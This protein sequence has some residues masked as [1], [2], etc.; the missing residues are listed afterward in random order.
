MSMSKENFE[1]MIENID[2]Y[3]A[4]CKE[5]C[6]ESKEEFEE[7]T[8]KEIKKRVEHGRVLQSKI[9]KIVTAE[10]YHV[11]GMGDLTVTQQSRFIKKIKEL[12][13]ARQYLK[14][15][16]MFQLTDIPNIP[17]ETEYKCSAL[18]VK[19]HGKLTKM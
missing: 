3:I 9:D 14:P 13:M 8:F 4:E 2:N 7:L 19:L 17:D 12:A 16:A 5:I 18:G 11:I 1:R 6:V 10:L 15:L